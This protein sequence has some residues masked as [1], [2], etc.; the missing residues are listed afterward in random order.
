MTTA[1]FHVKTKCFP[2]CAMYSV[3]PLIGDSLAVLMQRQP[4]ELD[5]VL[6]TCFHKVKQLDGVYSVQ[7]P[8]FWTLCSD[9]YIG[10]LKLEVASG[11]DTKFILSQ[12]HNIFTAVT[13]LCC[14]Y[15]E[16]L[17]D[18]HWCRMIALSDELLISDSRIRS[19]HCLTVSNR[20]YAI[21]I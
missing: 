14:L 11:A 19:L 6:P 10:A 17:F 3:V 2:F 4:K 12:T 15:L 21:E 9:V 1:K 18:W 5:D 7:E 16:Y 20:C 8:H 13:G